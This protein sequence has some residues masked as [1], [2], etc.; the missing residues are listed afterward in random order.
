[1]LELDTLRLLVDAGTIVICAGGG[2]IPVIFDPFGRVHGVDA[3]VDK[4]HSTALVA[5]GLGADVLLLLT[6]VDGVYVDWGTPS[7]RALGHVRP[8]E[9][10]ALDLPEG[11]MRP[12]AEAAAR[13]VGRTGGFAAIGALEDAA[14]IVRGE[15]GTRIEAE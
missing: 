2:G 12:K 4:D 11:S 1:V 3:V 10:L 14:A 9:L 13:F 15:A 8:E 7:A 5:E 6:D